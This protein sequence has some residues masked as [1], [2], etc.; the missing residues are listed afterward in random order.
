[1]SDLLAPTARTWSSESLPPLTRG[2][3]D[4]IARQCH[5]LA[6]EAAKK[7]NELDRLQWSVLAEKWERVP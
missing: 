2:A 5:T 6:E 1:M 7:N 4:L 3:M